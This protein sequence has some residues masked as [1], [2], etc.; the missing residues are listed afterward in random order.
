MFSRDNHSFSQTTIWQNLDFKK[1]QQRLN[2]ITAQLEGVLSKSSQIEAAEF[3]D[4]EN[5]AKLRE[6]MEVNQLTES[7]AIAMIVSAFFSDTRQPLS[8]T[9]SSPDEILE[10]LAVLEQQIA[11]LEGKLL[12]HPGGNNYLV[13]KG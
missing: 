10:R 4:P 5:R 2:R 7:Q 1:V 9:P 12:V 3:I 13:E 6:F 8:S 11:E